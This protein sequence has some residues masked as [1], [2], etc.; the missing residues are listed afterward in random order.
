MHTGYLLHAV[1]RGAGAGPILEEGITVT[2]ARE[3]RPLGRQEEGEPEADLVGQRSEMEKAYLRAKEP[4]FRY[5]DPA[6]R[7]FRD[8]LAGRSDEAR[9][10]PV[11]DEED[12]GV[13]ER[14]PEAGPAPEAAPMPVDE[15]PAGGETAPA[16]PEVEDGEIEPVVAEEEGSRVTKLISKF[17]RAVAAARGSSDDPDPRGPGTAGR[18]GSSSTWMGKTLRR[19]NDAQPA[20]QDECRR[21]VQWRE[22]QLQEREE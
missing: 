13:G 6:Y 20:V 16:A 3:C 7:E 2:F 12:A 19:Q 21:L 8:T 18:I 1:T 14:I 22:R 4:S 17:S 5:D 11:L 9:A 10:W 15:E